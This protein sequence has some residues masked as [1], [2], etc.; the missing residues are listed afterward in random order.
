MNQ[1]QNFI[2]DDGEKSFDYRY[3]LFL[4]KKNFYIVFTF[5]IIVVTLASIYAAKIPNKYRATVQ[6]IIERSQNAFIDEGWDDQGISNQ[7]W[8]QEYYSTQEEIMLGSPIL[9]EVSDQLKLKEYF[10]TEDD[11]QV[12]KILKGMLMAKHLPRSRI[13]NVTADTTDPRLS[14]RLATAVARAYI[15]KSFQDSLFYNQEILGWL[16]QVEQQGNEKITIEDP[17]GNIKMVT[18]E[19][20]VESL[21][22]IQ[23]DTTLKELREKESGLLAD[24]ES[25][26]LQY[27]DKHPE[28]IKAR[29]SLKFIQDNIEKEKQVILRNLKSKARGK[30]KTSPGRIIEE[31]RVPE[32]PLPAKRLM[33][34]LLA[35]GMEIFLS[36]LILVLIDYFD[37]TIHSMEDMERKGILLPFLGPIPIL[38]G[39]YKTTDEVLLVTSPAGKSEL[40]EA[41]RYLR[42]AINFSAPPEAL[43]VLIVTSCLPHD[44]KSFTSQNLAASLAHDGN[45]TLLVDADLRRPVVHRHFRLDNSSGLSN[46]LTSN[47]D[48]EAVTKET[49]V[50][51]L[52]IIPSGPISP[53]PSEIL[54]SE[55]MAKFLEDAKSKFDRVIIDCP[56]LTGIGDG[57]V[58]GSLIGHL[59]LVISSGKTPADLIRH[60]QNH[61]EKSHIK[62]LGTILNKMDVERERHGGYTKYYYHTYNRYYTRDEGV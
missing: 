58:L 7:S 47:I 12:V 4:V 46:Y 35:G 22:A 21:P 23:T 16:E 40:A 44:G 2:L 30:F 31:A 38:R 6:L 26:S 13:F 53:N 32:A 27:R 61:L 3:Y 10:E 36:V 25:L 51:N 52:F 37:D 9:K 41:F 54:G 55:R 56:P 20:L 50:E 17:F 43:K 34:V 57:F 39:K 14:A 24:I 11:D 49:F 8:T 48:M 18:K 59:I 5:L 42:V 45:K 60:T 15:R 62:V 33:M 28:M 29:A 19:E 1:E